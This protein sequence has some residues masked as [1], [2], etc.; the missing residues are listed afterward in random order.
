MAIGFSSQRGEKGMVAIRRVRS[1]MAIVGLIAVLCLRT[2]A[3]RA[4]SDDPSRQFVEAGL[5]GWNIELTVL[6]GHPT[7]RAS[8]MQLDHTGR[9]QIDTGDWR[10]E[11][12]TEVRTGRL[13]NESTKKAFR[14]V[15]TTINKFSLE[16]RRKGEVSHPMTVRIAI[17]TRERQLRVEYKELFKI[18]EVGEEI[19]DFISELNK[20]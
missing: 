13:S 11:R 20:Q 17:S 5:Q 3:D 6:P 2:S 15:S 18:E 16:D 19:H 12:F 7:G 8:R 1:L 9:F 14:A 10:G 4:L